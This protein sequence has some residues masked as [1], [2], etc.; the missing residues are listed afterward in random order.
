MPKLVKVIVIILAIFI[1]VILIG[2]LLGY[3]KVPYCLWFCICI[4]FFCPII[5]KGLIESKYNP[6][7]PMFAKYLLAVMKGIYLSVLSVLVSTL[8]LSPLGNYYAAN[9]RND[10]WD[11]DNSFKYLSTILMIII[12]VWIV[13]VFYVCISSVSKPKETEEQE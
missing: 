2:E 5:K 4:F 6:N 3:E 12:A 13:Y 10:Y 9:K 7:K 1:G 8:I 11:S